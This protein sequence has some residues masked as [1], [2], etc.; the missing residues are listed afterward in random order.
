MAVKATSRADEWLKRMFWLLSRVESRLIGGYGDE[1]E[2]RGV[3]RE[4]ERNATDIFYC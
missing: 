4:A 3:E 2:R 1:E